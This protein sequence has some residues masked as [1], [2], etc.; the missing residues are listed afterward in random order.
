MK[1]VYA[2]IA[3][4]VV[5]IVCI[6]LWGFEFG[7]ERANFTGEFA[8]Y[9]TQGVERGTLAA[10]YGGV[11][12]PMDG[13]HTDQLLRVLCRGQAEMQ[14]VAAPPQAY[15]DLLVLHMGDMEVRVYQP[16]LKVDTVVMER[17]LGGKSVCKNIRG[18]RMLEWL[19]WICGA[20]EQLDIYD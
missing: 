12:Y 6:G 16:D 10:E 8:K 3:V 20:T 4:A 17:R 15:E 14:R 9:L 7:Y 2:V 19:K 13:R 5:M 1:K 11:S 18:Y